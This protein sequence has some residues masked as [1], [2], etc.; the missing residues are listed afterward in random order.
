MAQVK[1]CLEDKPKCKLTAKQFKQLSLHRDVSSISSFV[2]E[3]EAYTEFCEMK[4]IYGST[5]CPGMVYSNLFT[6][7]E[8]IAVC[9]SAPCDCIRADS[10]LFLRGECLSTVSGTIDTPD[11]NQLG[12]ESGGK[13]GNSR[14]QRQI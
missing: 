7:S 10:L 12:N 11:Y 4:S 5:I 9:I 1:Q 8:D 6:D 2:E 13:T 14:R 3:I